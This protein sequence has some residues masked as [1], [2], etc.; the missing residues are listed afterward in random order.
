MVDVRDLV[1]NALSRFGWPVFQQGSLADD[2][3]YP[4]SFFTFWV[5]DSSGVYYSNKPAQ[6]VYD[7]TVNF[8]TSNPAYI[9]PTMSAARDALR[10]AGFSVTG[11]GYDVAS[12]EPT[13]AGRGM[14]VSYIDSEG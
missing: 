8:Y 13:H 5:N 4:E 10:G 14:A 12:D 2:D 9:A 6:T 3:P 7:M 1:C 11:M